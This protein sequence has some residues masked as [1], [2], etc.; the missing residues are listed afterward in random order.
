MPKVKI[1]KRVP[2]VLHKFV[3]FFKGFEKVEAVRRLFGEQTTKILNNLKVEF[4]SSRWGYMGVNDKDGHL[5]VSA[6]Y[7]KKGDP[8]DIYLDIIHEFVH[9]K[10]FLEGKELFE[11]GFEYVDLPTEIEAYRYCI[12][13]AKRLGMSKEEM[14]E[15]LSV[16]WLE[17]DEV[18]RLARNVGIMS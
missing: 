1:P 17:S 4:F 5:M 11:D 9:I 18:E 15:Y 10:Q 6:H 2:V 13:E 16:E 12:E 7:L 3:E 8:R 14:L